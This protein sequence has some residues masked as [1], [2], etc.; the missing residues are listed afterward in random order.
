MTKNNL[1]RLYEGE[2]KNNPSLRSEIEELGRA[3]DIAIKLY[4][5][6][7]D[8]GLTQEQLAQKMG[9]SQSNVARWESPGYPGYS[10]TTLDK[11]ADVLDIN[12]T[13]TFGKQRKATITSRIKNK[14]TILATGFSKLLS[15]NQETQTERSLQPNLRSPAQDLQVKWRAQT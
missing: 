11:I 13:I 9:V 10:T 4:D 8:S 1:Q 3:I 7:E 14:A 2:F 5:L 15:S 6:R 12:F